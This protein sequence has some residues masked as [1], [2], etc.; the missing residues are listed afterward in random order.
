M[1][2]VLKSACAS[3]FLVFISICFPNHVRADDHDDDGFSPQGPLNFGLVV[4]NSFHTLY[5]S[6]HLGT[7]QLKRLE[8]YL[9]EENLPFPEIVIHMN[10][11]GF[12]RSFPMF[13][14]FALQEYELSFQYGYRFYHA[15]DYSFRTYLDG[16]N[17][18]QPGKNI[19]GT[20]YLGDK[21]QDYFG[22]I[23]HP[24]PDGGIDAFM[25]IMH[26]ILGAR[27][28]VLF[29]CTGGKHRTGMVAMAIRY[30]QGGDWITGKKRKVT[31][32]V[33]GPTLYLNPAQY[34][35]YLHNS[36]QFRTDNMDFIEEFY[37]DQRF[38]ELKNLYHTTL[39][40][41]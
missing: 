40:A 9:E 15:F 4:N 16:D 25:R 8:D 31:V 11:H 27:Q 39:T 26:L 5:R 33:F 19:D 10:R 22:V 34:E 36:W 41:P 17:P 23:D 2:I 24:A 29:H 13:S 35:Y 28:P 38:Q 21:A 30:L 14:H 1:R 18:Y 12:K 32:N 37:K 3:F 7:D 20:E 6:E